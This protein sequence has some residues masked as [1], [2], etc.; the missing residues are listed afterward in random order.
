MRRGEIVPSESLFEACFVEG[1]ELAP[2]FLVDMRSLET[3]VGAFICTCDEHATHGQLSD[4]VA[5]VARMALDPDERAFIEE[6]APEWPEGE[7]R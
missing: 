3:R 6:H 1:C 5:R 4:A 7:T 2:T